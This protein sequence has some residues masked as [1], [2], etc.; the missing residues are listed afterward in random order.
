[1]KSSVLNRYAP[2]LALAALQLL[3]VTMSDP[4]TTNTAL[5]AGATNGATNGSLVAGA[6]AGG[7]LGTAADGTV[8]GGVVGSGGGAN[9]TVPGATG[10]ANQATA[11][12]NDRS[13]CAPGG[14]LQEAVSFQSPPCMPKFVGDNGGATFRGVTKDKI[15]IVVFYPKYPGAT[16]QV[17]AANNLAMTPEKGAEVHEILEKFFNKHYEFY[18]RQIN[19]EY[20][21]TE[22]PDAATMRADAKAIVAKFNPFAVLYYAQGLGPA[23]FHEQLAREG[24]LNLGVMPVA[25]EFFINNSP[26]VWSQVIQGY[27]FAD[28]SSEYYCKRMYGKNATLAGDPQMR[29]KKRK[30]GVMASEAPE[31][32]AVAK[33]FIANV[34]GG[35]CGTKNDGTTLYTYSSDPAIAEDQRPALVTRLKEDGITTIRGGSVCKEGDQQQYLPEIFAAEVF[36]D[37]F[38]GRV[39]AALC[40]PTQMNQVFGIGLFPKANPV[41]EKEWYKAMQDAQPGYEGPYLAEGPFQGLALLARMIQYAGPNLTPQSVLAGTRKTPQIGGFVNANPWPGWKCCNPYTAE[42]NIAIDANS[43][44]AKNDARQIY[45]DNAARSEGDGVQGSWVGVDNSKRYRRGAWT[46]GEPK[47]P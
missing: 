12:A 15:T 30:L 23:A 43:Y 3:L 31:S 45:W 10:V 5:N 11:V 46:K 2:F 9:N 1:M 20:Y 19:V 28:M 34:T 13:K 47:Q 24:V 37:D 21:S 36:D 35:M 42:Y 44:S 6:A 22:Q 39:Y 27:R 29:L 4:A 7:A 40:G 33:H 17:L 18:G 32:V 26:L 25:D 38:V 8:G 14:L 16:Q 41:S